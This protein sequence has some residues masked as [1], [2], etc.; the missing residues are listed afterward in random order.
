MTQAAPADVPALGQVTAQM[1]DSIAGE[2]A[3]R[4]AQLAPV[5]GDA[6][7]WAALAATYEREARARASEG[8]AAAALLH[9]AGRVHEE[10]LSSLPDA[11]A[12]YRAALE[13]HPAHRPS[14]EAARRVAHALGDAD[15]ECRLLESQAAIARDGAEAAALHL[16]RA[17]ILRERLGRAADAR[18]ALAQ[19]AAADPDSLP[20]A[21]AEGACAAAEGRHEDLVAAYER[22]AER[23]DDPALA[24]AWLCG[25]AGVAEGQLDRVDRATE[26]ALRAFALAPGERAVREVARRLAERSGRTEHLARVLEADASAPDAAPRDAALAWCAIARLDGPPGRAEAALERALQIG[27]DDPLVLDELARS[28]ELR[29]DWERLADVLRRRAAASP[30]GDAERDEIARRNLHLGEICEERLGRFD[31]AAACYRAALALEPH[32]R[33]ALAALGRLYGRSG[34]WERVLEIFLAQRDTSADPEERAQRCVRAAQVLEEHLSRPSDAIALYEEVLSLEPGHVAAHTALERLY[35]RSGRFDA[36]ASLLERD[37]AAPADPVERLSLLFRLARLHEDRL[38]DREAA[39]RTYERILD[40]APE[41]VV[42]L[43]A[44]AALDERLGHFDDLVAL[45]RRLAE[46]TSDPRKVIALLQRAAEVQEGQLGDQAAAA[47]THEAILRLDPTHVPS[48]RALGRF[49]AHAGR[50]E[51]LVAM[52][53]AEADVLTSAEAAAALHARAGAILETKLERPAEAAEAYRQ[54]LALAPSDVTALRALA[55]LGRERGAWESLVEVLR[56]QAATACSSERKASLFVEAGEILE[57]RLGAVQ[58]AAAVYEDAL[59]ACP[60]SATALRAQDRVFTAMGRWVS[61]L[62]VRRA[63]ADAAP[64]GAARAAALLECARLAADRIG[65]VEAAVEACRAALVEVPA[66]LEALILLGRLQGGLGRAS[67][68]ANIADRVGDGCAAATLLVAAALERGDQEGVEPDLAR[69]AAAAPE[70]PVAAPLADAALRRAGS[71]TAR[72]E[73]WLARMGAAADPEER[74]QCALRAGEAWEEAGHTERAVGAFRDAIDALPPGSLA[75]LHALRRVRARGGAWAEVR[76]T[77][78]EEG[79]AARDA[80]LAAS[81]FSAAGEIALSRLA[82]RP[83]AAADWRR[84]LERDPLDEARAERLTKLLAE[85]G[86]Q[87]ELCALHEIRAAAREDAGRRAED[88][89]RAARIAADGLGDA[90]RSLAAL[91]GALAARADWVPALLLRARV[92]ASAGRPDDAAENLAA[93]LALGGDPR[94]V[95]QS[96]LALEALYRGPLADPTR[97]MSHLNAALAAAPDDPEALSRLARVHRQA[98]NWPAAA[99]ALRRLSAARAFGPLE[100]AGALIDLAEV[101]AEGF[102]DLAAARELSGRALELAPDDPSLRARAARFHDGAS[103]PGGVVAALQAAAAAAPGPDRARA[104]LR[105]ARVLLG[106]FDDD[107]LA[108][109]ELQRAL[110]SDPDHTEARAALAEIYAGSD[111]PLAIEEHRRMLA[112][113]PARLASWR[114]LYALF[115][116]ANAHDHAFVVAAVLRFLQVSAPAL[117]GAFYAENSLHAPSGTQQALAAGDWSALRHPGDG[118]SLAEVLRLCSGALAEA[119]GLQPAKEKLKDAQ[120]LAGL[121]DELCVNIDLATP[122]LRPA[123]GADALAEPG[124]RPSVR[125]GREMTRR[126]SEGEQ[127]FLLARAAAHLRRGSALATRVSNEAFGELVAAAIRQVVPGYDATGSPSPALVKA[128]GRALPRRVRKALEGPA[129]AFARAGSVDV[130]AWRTAAEATADRTGLLL[131]VD[132]PAALALVARERGVEAASDP[133][134]IASAV[135]SCAALRQLVLFAISEDHLRLRQRLRLAIA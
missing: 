38:G 24:A 128:V 52:Y 100:R 13:F 9:E 111:P 95:A 108:I 6:M 127:R 29:G 78:Q 112:A 75:P 41:H 101:R 30:S 87:A 43:E 4:T 63:A 3:A 27:E 57:R 82:D 61:L 47:A 58:R 26:L 102:A 85:S 37:V 16:A 12:R 117:D 77:F 42:A 93:C 123:D 98:S 118:G 55:R 114:A 36:L 121:L 73:L 80:V 107:R 39:A 113:D 67:A 18:A 54:A 40:F 17:L 91:D 92:L 126:R 25:A 124:T 66:H 72:A 21:D 11:L 28:Y 134:E 68:R 7:D 109:G 50:W 34:D 133:V 2:L 22:C 53:R 132:I 48:L 125:V 94:E 51:D 69:A 89:L 84:A 19:A 106:A 62:E 130:A 45:H 46:L 116:T 71:H 115:R 90:E 135:R 65:D 96:H 110:A 120:A 8:P 74:G 88:F 119:A 14:L 131:A 70:H 20:V 81:A 56:A 122:A 105:A 35:E 103:N 44:L 83:G 33:G 86:D 99:D 129:R 23:V 31:E 76:A 97:A 104:H 59:R 64:A 49:F 32:H 10:R 1:G 5:P 79:A 60:S 15:A